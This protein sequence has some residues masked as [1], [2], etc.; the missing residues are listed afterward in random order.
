MENSLKMGKNSR[1]FFCKT[2]KVDFHLSVWLQEQE[3]G[4]GNALQFDWLLKNNKS[5]ALK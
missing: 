1:K 3:N 4:K 2:L 5:A